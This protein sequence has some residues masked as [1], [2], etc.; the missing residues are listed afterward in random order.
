M[1]R[2][3]FLGLL[4]LAPAAPLIAKELAKTVE[5]EVPPLPV[6]AVRYEGYDSF[7]VTAGAY[8][9][10]SSYS[11]SEIPASCPDHASD[12]NCHRC[13]I[14]DEW[15]CSLNAEAHLTWPARE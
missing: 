3:G 13:D 14:C 7:M 2:R 4:G 12:A 8:S 10:S 5:A 11:W 9:G 6:Q 1:K 15:H